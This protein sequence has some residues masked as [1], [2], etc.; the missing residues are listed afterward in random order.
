MKMKCPN[1]GAELP[2]GAGFCLHCFTVI[3][4]K[5][6]PQAQKAPSKGRQKLIIVII[7]ALVIAAGAVAVFCAAG[8]PEK[9]PEQSE[10]VV[11]VS[12]ESTTSAARTA[13]QS[14]EKSTEKKTEKPAETSAST[15]A[16]SQTEAQ[17]GTASTRADT[18][19]TSG[20]TTKKETTA[21]ETTAKKEKT[22][23]KESTAVV[24]KNGVLLKY[25]AARKSSSYT[26]PY[27]VTSISK[28]AFE[29][30]RYLKTLKF[31]KRENLKCD[32]NNLF[33]ALP[34]LKTIYIYAGTSADTEG[35]QYFG[36]EIIYYYD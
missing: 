35:M 34:N 32:W 36:G 1:C 4:E 13:A 19:Q 28:N 18:E 27:G 7:S 26:I 11:A 14:T 20:E 24:I 33:S 22:T 30:N 16:T 29:T 23:K 8:R 12:T 15:E 25:P 17:T 3:G 21:K 6:P 2:Q 10:G 31:S 5:K 9:A